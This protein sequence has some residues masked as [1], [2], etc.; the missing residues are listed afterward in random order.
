MVNNPEAELRIPNKCQQGQAIRPLSEAV[1]ILE[2]FDIREKSLRALCDLRRDAAW[3]DSG[4]AVVLNA[5]EDG[6]IFPSEK[7]VE[8]EYF[9]SFVGRPTTWGKPY[10]SDNRR[11]RCDSGAGLGR[12]R[13][14]LIPA[15]RGGRGKQDLLGQPAGNA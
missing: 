9:P 8:Q 14:A 3:G 4:A 13:A 11:R 10:R 5:S 2:V 1:E 7:I 15:Y 6:F 12:L